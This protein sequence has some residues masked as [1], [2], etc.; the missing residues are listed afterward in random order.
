MPAAVGALYNTD[1]HF[2]SEMIQNADDNAYGPGVAPALRIELLPRQGVVITNNELG[3]EPHHVK[4]LSGLGQSSKSKENGQ[5]GEKGE[6]AVRRMARLAAPMQQAHARWH[7]LYMQCA[8]ACMLHACCRV[9][10]VRHT[11]GQT[12]TATFNHRSC[13]HQL[14]AP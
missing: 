2:L 1:A 4:A 12:H 10:V 7:H 5:T 14:R 6:E 11:W 3:F 9:A 8:H 13:H